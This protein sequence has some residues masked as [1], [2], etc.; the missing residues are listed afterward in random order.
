ML[1]ILDNDGVLVDSE[2]IANR[3]LSELLTECG[4]PISYDESV[5]RYL[6]GT[7]ALVRADVEPQLGHALPDDLEAT[8]HQRLFDRVRAEL[9]PVEGAEQAITD[10]G[11]PMCVAS[12]GTHER[13]ELEL[14][15]T[16]LYD[17][18][19][20]RLFS[21]EDVAR[22]KPHPDL[23][24]HVASELGVPAAEC[25]VVEDSPHGVAAARAAGMAVV[26]YAGL[27]PADRLVDAD[28]VIGTMAE[29]P[30]AVRALAVA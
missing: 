30:G 16:G 3:V 8:Y 29:L 17:R 26:G 12:S 21:A 2:P 7:L 15:T 9:H 1:L 25:V 22:G 28:A 6:G 24:L 11:W 18:F 13:I 20:G 27:T 14:R 4:Y 5:R 23:F 19:V 10:V